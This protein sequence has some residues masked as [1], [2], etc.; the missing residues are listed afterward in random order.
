MVRAQS[1]L[2][3]A[4]GTAAGDLLLLGVDTQGDGGGKPTLLAKSQK[5]GTGRCSGARRR[6]PPAPFF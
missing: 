6:S 2:T 3:G 5:P 1:K 4:R